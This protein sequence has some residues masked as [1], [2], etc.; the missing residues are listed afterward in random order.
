MSRAIL[1]RGARQLLTLHG[2]TGARR[3]HAL[4]NLGLIED[5]SLLVLDGLITNVGPTRRIENLAE[6]RNADEI[7]ASGKV[8]MPGFVDSHSNLIAAPAR[9]FDYRLPSGSGEGIGNEGVAEDL[10]TATQY[11]RT[12][13]AKM[14]ELQAR[15]AVDLMI[16]HG[17]TTLEVKTGYGMSEAAEVKTLRA[18]AALEDRITAIGTYWGMGPFAPEF[19]SDPDDYINWI[20]TSLLPKLRQKRLARF[21]DLTV[22]GRGFSLEQGRAILHRARS[23]G[24]VPKVQASSTGRSDGVRLAIEAEAA[25]AD[26]LNHVESSDI[27]VLARSSTVATLLPGTVHQGSFSR[28]APA[29]ELIDTG[30]A[31]ALATGFNPGVSSTINMQMVI[32]LA[33]THTKMTPEEAI[34]AATING[35]HAVLDSHQCGS[36]AFGKR[37]DVVMLN[38]PDYRELAFHFGGNLLSMCMRGGKVVVADGVGA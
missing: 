26:G 27:D 28:F 8:V 30:A 7:N 34:S 16:R 18:A 4:R 12:T 24:F 38:V 37:A 15:R 1:I 23:L 9:L 6:A 29:R 3:G 14:L 31:V 19:Q 35:A 5:G 13:A 21:V 11:I 32:A 10:H 36:L 20:C 22:G 2:P 17:T 33:C 25:S